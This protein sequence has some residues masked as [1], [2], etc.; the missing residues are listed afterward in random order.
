MIEILALASGLRDGSITV[1]PDNTEL[2]VEAGAS[3]DNADCYPMAALVF[4]RG[5]EVVLSVDCWKYAAWDDGRSNGM[6]PDYRVD[7]S[8]GGTCGRPHVKWQGDVITI[9][10]GTTM[11]V[12]LDIEG[13]DEDAIDEA[14]V[15][16][17]IETVQEALDAA[18]DTIEVSFPADEDER[19]WLVES[20]PVAVLAVDDDGGI[21]FRT[22]HRYPSGRRSDPDTDGL[23][24]AIYAGMSCGRAIYAVEGDGEDK[25]YYSGEDAVRAAREFLESKLREA[26][27]HASDI[28][29]RE[30]GGEV[31]RLIEK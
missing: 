31:D 28:D 1:T 29:A 20:G 12:T 22:G 21:D 6:S 30:F 23:C 24:V 15:D 2:S 10:H 7:D 14:A 26:V 19:T 4:R 5:E 9:R 13:A 16:A 11:G 17:A 25:L 18:Y 8:D 27:K 3:I